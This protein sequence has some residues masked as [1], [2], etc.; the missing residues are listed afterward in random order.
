MTPCDWFLL[1]FIVVAIAYYLGAIP[2]FCLLVFVTG[3]LV[4]RCLG[5]IFISDQGHPKKRSTI[6]D[7]DAG[8][9]FALASRRDR[10]WWSATSGH[11]GEGED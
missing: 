9:M 7:Y 3:V 10:E 11:T 2:W 6:A 5:A 1:L 4:A 8:K